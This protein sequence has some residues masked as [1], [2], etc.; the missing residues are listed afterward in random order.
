MEKSELEKIEDS[1]ED[2]AISK[3]KQV[4]NAVVKKDEQMKKHTTFKIGGNADIYVEVSSVNDLKEI[5][6]IAKK[7]KIDVFILG[8]G[9]NLLVKENGI[10][11]IVIKIAFD[12]ITMNREDDDYYITAYAGASL[13]EVVRFA[14]DKGVGDVS[15]L[16]GI[17]GSIGGV[18]R[19]NA[20]AYDLEMKDVICET[21]YMDYDGNLHKIKGDEHNFGYRT[22]IFKYNNGIIICTTFKLKKVDKEKQI[23]EAKKILNMR[24]TNQPLEYP[25]AGSTFK[26][27]I[28]YIASLLIDNSGLKGTTVGGAEVST[29]HAGFIINKSGDANA[30][31]V[32]DLV[33][34]VQ[35]TVKEKTG[36]NLELEV[37]VVGE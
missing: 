4:T 13:N 15:R 34:I 28:G 1:I 21:T 25:S 12:S 6:K 22:S 30:K 17:P 3:I 35:D 23:K 20:G 33:K 27:G 9:S 7:E 18:V 10:R 16:Y 37:I 5:L 14:M 11:G 29:K 36:K 8:N 32:L 31:D 24:K 26:R 19:M 2:K